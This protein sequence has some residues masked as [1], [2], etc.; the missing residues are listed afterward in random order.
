[1]L[2]EVFSTSTEITFWDMGCGHRPVVMVTVATNHRCMH[3]ICILGCVVMVTVANN[4]R[5]IHKCSLGCV[6]LVTV[7]NNHRCVGMC[8]L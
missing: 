2:R 1:M 6:V 7:A 5:C 3:S 4:H 8:T